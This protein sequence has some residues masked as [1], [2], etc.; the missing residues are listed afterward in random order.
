MINIHL[1][2]YPLSY[3]HSQFPS[4]LPRLR[5][6]GPVR[7]SKSLCLTEYQQS[8]LEG[9]GLFCPGSVMSLGAENGSDNNTSGLYNKQFPPLS[10]ATTSA[11]D[12]LSAFGCELIC[13]VVPS[14]SE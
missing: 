11:G 7:P 8:G 3:V 2:N 10:Q 13:T 12:I 4:F 6:S 9:H 14:Y 1:S 5:L